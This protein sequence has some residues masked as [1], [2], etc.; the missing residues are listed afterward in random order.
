MIPGFTTSRGA[1]LWIAVIAVSLV[2]IFAASQSS[3]LAYRD[4][5]YIAAGF[6]GVVAMVLLL[7]QPLLAAGFLAGLAGVQGRRVHKWIGVVVVFLIAAHVV[8]LWITSPPDVID[9]L[10]FSSPTPFSH[11]GVIAMWCL[12]GTGCVA[13]WRRKMKPRSWRLVHK[14]LAIIIVVSAVV[15]AMLIEGTMEVLSKSLL[16]AMVLASTVIVLVLLRRR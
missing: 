15:H 10:L 16:C 14:T 6:A 13:L 11:W 8:G 9:A 7:F 2:S 5:V 12:L 3:L 1:L 4:P